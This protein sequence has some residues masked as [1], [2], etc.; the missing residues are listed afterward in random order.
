M[1]RFN[2]Q[3]TLNF[4]IFF[5][6][7]FGSQDSETCD[8]CN[9]DDDEDDEQTSPDI[10]NKKPDKL[11]VNFD[12]LSI[13]SEEN[14]TNSSDEVDGGTT[15]VPSAMTT[16]TAS[17]PVQ[18]PK[19]T[20]NICAALTDFQSIVPPLA[21]FENLKYEEIGP[22][23]DSSGEVRYNSE[24][25]TTTGETVIPCEEWDFSGPSLA[26]ENPIQSHSFTTAESNGLTGQKHFGPDICL[27]NALASSQE[28]IYAEIQK[29]TT[30]PCTF[31]VCLL[32]SP[33]S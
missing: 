3:R 15:A 5:R 17:I 32:A 18:E 23:L 29:K 9:E 10:S 31:Q 16:A 22:N 6:F 1:G 2:A 14:F 25:T 21:H 26:Q 20:A 19:T 24:S 12:H 13:V 30:N 8:T 27:R 4:T 7:I 28:P 33:A 11:H